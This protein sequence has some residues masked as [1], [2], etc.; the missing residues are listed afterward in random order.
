MSDQFEAS[1]TNDIDAKTTSDRR[2]DKIQNSYYE[3]RFVWPLTSRT[4]IYSGVSFVGNT[5]ITTSNHHD[6]DGG[7]DGVDAGITKNVDVIIQWA[8]QFH[9]CSLHLQPS[10]GDR[11][12]ETQPV[13]H[14]QYIA[15][16]DN[17]KRNMR[18]PNQR[19]VG[20]MATN[21]WE[22]FT[23]ID[24]S[25]IKVSYDS[26]PQ[27]QT[28]APPTSS[29]A[30]DDDNNSV[31]GT[32]N[33][34]HRRN[35]SLSSM[36]ESVMDSTDGITNLLDSV[37]VS[38]IHNNSSS[39]PNTPSISG[40]PPHHHRH[41][42]SSSGEFMTTNTIDANENNARSHSVP[43]I[44]YT[45]HIGQILVRRNK[46]RS[47]CSH[48]ANSE[49][50]SDEYRTNLDFR[51]LVVHISEV[52]DKINPIQMIWVGS[53]D[54][55]Q[56]H[57]YMINKQ[58]IPS[59]IRDNEVKETLN[60][61]EKDALRP[62]R[63][64][65]HVDFVVLSPVMAMQHLQWTELDTTI[66]KHCLIMACQDGTVRL[67][68]FDILYDSAS[69]DEVSFHNVQHNQ[70]IIDG[71]IVAIHAKRHV[72]TQTSGPLI[73]HVTIGSLCGYVAELYMN[74]STMEFLTKEGPL[75]VAQ[76]FWNCR[77]HVEDSV[78][79]VYRYKHY[80]CVG[81]Q[82]GRCYIYRNLF[83][84]TTRTSAGDMHLSMMEFSNKAVYHMEWSCQLPYPIHFIAMT[85]DQHLFVA[86]SRSVHLFQQ[87]FHLS[88]TNQESIVK[89]ANRI[90]DRIMQL[91]RLTETM[92]NEPEGSTLPDAAVTSQEQIPVVD[93][94]SDAPVEHFGPRADNTNDKQQSTNTLLEEGKDSHKVT[95][96]MVVS[97]LVD[98]I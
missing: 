7:D 45:N 49:S 77:L 14:S 54:Q 22:V 79:S 61:K 69:E 52:E 71:P 94:M 44:T 62:I 3:E 55:N 17:Q 82:A 78:M 24:T 18:M 98:L 66:R 93:S 19:C 20:Y 88:R 64:D 29:N 92:K 30:P 39:H 91:Q 53:A 57:C 2:F 97:E 32:N 84:L 74:S 60:A 35:S 13:L 38:S 65:Q 81:T 68:V 12:H 90:K 50:V 51:P 28:G 9:T 63:I 48:A 5:A 75:M 87:R 33:N 73:I 43:N 11:Q 70:V 46:R 21:T 42:S 4:T 6:N 10:I 34:H 23:F 72:A 26:I 96:S 89:S 85:S 47:V 67:V 80:V 16:N 37:L 27:K 40:P 8:T 36:P 59:I 41:P 31:T 25:K 95:A 15:R 58:N 1:I 86:T 83:A 56:L 76:G